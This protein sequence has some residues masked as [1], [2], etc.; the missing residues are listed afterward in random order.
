MGLAAGGERRWLDMQLLGKKASELDVEH[1]KMFA[2]LRQKFIW[3]PTF[4]QR[5]LR[6]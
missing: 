5:P 4:L 3:V 6:S 2:M 1:I